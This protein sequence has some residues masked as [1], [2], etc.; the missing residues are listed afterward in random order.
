MLHVQ[1]V[2][3]IMAARIQVPHSLKAATPTC[4]S[5]FFVSKK[6]TPNYCSHSTFG[7]QW[8]LGI[9]SI[10]PE[11]LLPSLTRSLVSPSLLHQPILWRLFELCFILIIGVHIPL[12]FECKFPEVLLPSHSRSASRFSF[13]RGDSSQRRPPIASSSAALATIVG[14]SYFES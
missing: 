10:I 6:E 13:A 2:L 9:D 11:V 8:M 7:F 1:C 14:R 12:G 5:W 3:E 4:E